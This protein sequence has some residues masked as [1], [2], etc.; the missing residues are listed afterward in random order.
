MDGHDDYCTECGR[1][2]NQKR[3]VV[4]ELCRENGEYYFINPNKPMP[5]NI[6]QGGF[7]FGKNCASKVG[8]VWDK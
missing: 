5:E 6:S 3:L 7:L 2:L 4:L 8:R 1:K